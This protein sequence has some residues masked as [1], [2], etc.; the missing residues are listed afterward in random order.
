MELYD[1]VT[2]LI[3]PIDP[4]GETRTD[5]ARLVNL[6]VMAELVNSLILDIHFVANF[7][8]SHEASVKK[9][10]EYAKHFIEDMKDD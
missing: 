3:G 10:G 4:V 6:K 1:V 5:A 7:H 2:K 9:A 8:S